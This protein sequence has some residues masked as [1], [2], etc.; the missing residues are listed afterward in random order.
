MLLLY[1]SA[2]V[3]LLGVKMQNKRTENERERETERDREGAREKHTDT[4]R[5]RG[6]DMD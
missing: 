2:L 3:Q 1:A 5:Y 4:S 6:K